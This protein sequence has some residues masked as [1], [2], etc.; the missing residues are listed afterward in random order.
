MME[1]MNYVLLV[2]ANIKVWCMA[3]QP[4][5]G[6]WPAFTQLPRHVMVYGDR[7][8]VLHPNSHLEDQVSVFMIPRDIG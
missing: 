8:S 7:L 1:C 5:T 2:Y 4:T 3:Q 6:P